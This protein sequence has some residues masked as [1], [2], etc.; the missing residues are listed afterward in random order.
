MLNDKDKAVIEDMCACGMSLE[1]LYI[2]FKNFD[3]ADVK[4]AYDHFSKNAG[5]D[6]VEDITISRNCS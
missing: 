5:G 4:A 3:K 1:A 6:V 2:A